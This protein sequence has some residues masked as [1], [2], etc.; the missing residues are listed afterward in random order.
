M[1]KQYISVF[2]TLLFMATVTVPSVVVLF[3]D[4]IDVSFLLDTSEEEEEKGKDKNQEL[5]VFLEDALVNSDDLFPSETQ[6]N[7]E[8]TYKK[9]PIPHLNLISPPPEYIS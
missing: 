3:D 2:F 9:Y 5:E 8:Y 6:N 7:L 1:I 4:T